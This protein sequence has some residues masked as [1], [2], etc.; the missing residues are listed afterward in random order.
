[1]PFDINLPA[2]GSVLGI[3]VDIVDVVRIKDL[4]DRQGERFIDRVY[5][6][7]EKAYCLG[8][9]FPHTHLAARFAAKEAISKAFST[10]IGEHLNWKSM[11]V[12]LGERGQP[13][14]ELDEK[15]NELLK[16]L[17][18]SSVLLSLSHTD[19]A[20]IAFAALVGDG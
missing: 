4:H 6:E 17:G 9:R 2:Y 10:G 18:A 7:T 16:A 12:V 11:R 13:L 5:T 19:T 14:V 15:G 1:M 8:M 3:G 20:A